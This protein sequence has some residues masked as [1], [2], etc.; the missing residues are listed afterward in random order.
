MHRGT[1]TTTITQHA[2]THA[3]IANRYGV[4]WAYVSA[5][6][7]ASSNILVVLSTYQFIAN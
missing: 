2:H 4:A 5:I 7:Y 1:A 6:A 3:H